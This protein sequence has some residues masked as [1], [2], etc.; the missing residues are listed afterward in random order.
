MSF[1]LEQS[2]MQH[3]GLLF[4]TLCRSVKPF[5]LCLLRYSGLVPCL[6]YKTAA[7]SLCRTLCQ[8]QQLLSGQGGDAAAQVWSRQQA[9]RLAK[10][11]QVLS[12]CSSLPDE[13]LGV[14][15]VQ[16]HCLHHYL[17]G[18]SLCHEAISLKYFISQSTDLFQSRILWFHR[19]VYPLPFHQ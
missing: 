11:A 18:I 4:E 7:L 17:Q 10:A 13:L 1:E 16:N 3:C 15:P 14:K 19:D 12:L 5:L 2:L 8:P 9:V 6:E